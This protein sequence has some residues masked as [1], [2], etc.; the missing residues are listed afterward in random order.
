MNFRRPR[1]PVTELEMTPLIDVI[2][3]LLIFFL[4][5]TTFVTSPGMTINRPKASN[6]GPLDQERITV[7]IPK[8]QRGAVMFRGKRLSYEE[9]KTALRK[10]HAK[11]TQAQVAI[12]ADETV[13]HKIVVEV[14]DLISGVGFQRIGIVTSPGGGKDTSSP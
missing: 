12:D 7:E 5:T 13:E 4:I 9:L 11:D 14:M 10:L 8:G 1:R 6:S 2:F 3:Q